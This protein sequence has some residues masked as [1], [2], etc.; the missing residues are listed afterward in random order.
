MYRESEDYVKNCDKVYFIHGIN[1]PFQWIS[2]ESTKPKDI[3]SWYSK[4]NDLRDNSPGRGI[5]L[6]TTIP[7][8]ALKI[9]PEILNFPP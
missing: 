8:N 3:I 7:K 4:N 1:K 6:D 9:Y 5:G 2:G